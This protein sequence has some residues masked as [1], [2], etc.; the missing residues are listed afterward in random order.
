MKHVRVVK[1]DER[2]RHTAEQAEASSTSKG[3]VK[4][5]E[6]EMAGVISEWI[7]EF[8]SKQRA[9]SHGIVANLFRLPATA[10]P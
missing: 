6:R 7:D 5:A 2:S 10:R 8:R 4:N 9:E 3:K 1:R